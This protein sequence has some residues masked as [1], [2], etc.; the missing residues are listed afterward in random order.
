V[1]SS[2]RRILRSL[3]REVRSPEHAA[4]FE[5]ARGRHPVLARHHTVLSVLGALA[6]ERRSAYAEKE[7]LTR[8]LVAEHQ[9]GEGS[10]WASVL[11]VAYYP[12]LS[13][14]RHRIYGDALTGDDLDQ[15]VLASFLSVVADFP[16]DRYRDRTALRLRQQTERRVFAAVR[17]EQREQELVQRAEP[18]DL[19]RAAER[20]WPETRPEPGG[21]PASP[22]EAAD[23]VVF[24][25]EHAGPMLDAE[26]FELVTATLV[27]GRRIPRYL[28]RAHPDLDPEE[29]KRLYQR[30]KRRHSRLLRRLRPALAHLRCPRT[31][32]DGLCL[33]GGTS[34]TKESTK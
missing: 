27:C 16:L 10:F 21:A 18:E 23:I 28:E 17:A 31:E 6:D 26:S 22:E 20:S 2:F 33:F 9:R 32:A 4:L 5:E 11:L 14:L 3:R 30:V 19:E 13:R 7:A 12:M 29:R 1:S 15:L 25:V 8:A 24:L 34:P